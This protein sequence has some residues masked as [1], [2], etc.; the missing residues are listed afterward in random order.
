MADRRK[1]A[2]V[3]AVG[4]ILAG[5]AALGAFVFVPAA[6]QAAMLRTGIPIAL[7][8]IGCALI[9]ARQAPAGFTLLLVALLI[10]SFLR[11]GWPGGG[12]RRG[13]PRRRPPPGGPSGAARRVTRTAALEAEMEG[14]TPVNGTVL[15]GTYENGVLE[16]MTREQ[17]MDLRSQISFDAD[18]RLLLDAY[19]DGRFPRW[20]E[21][22]DVDGDAGE[23]VAARAGTMGLEEAYEVL[24]LEPSASATDVREAHRSLVERAASEGADAGADTGLSIR[25]LDEAK[26]VL[27]GL[28]D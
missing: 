7:G 23:G 2:P 26:A 4:F 20:R 17:L 27:L 11:R 5:L 6:V 1:G 9:I 28:Q 16:E 22:A 21:H 8:V 24:G 19:L 12:W 10:A 15:A 14:H 18:S 25:R 13:G 3:S